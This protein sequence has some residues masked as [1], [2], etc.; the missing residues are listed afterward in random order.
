[1]C[2]RPTRWP[3]SKVIWHEV[4]PLR[5]VTRS[6]ATP[7]SMRST[8]TT[9]SQPALPPVEV[10][11][12]VRLSTT[13]T[14]ARSDWASFVAG[15]A[16]MQTHALAEAGAKTSARRLILSAAHA[17]QAILEVR[18]VLDDL[19]EANDSDRVIQRHLAIVDL[20]QEVHELFRA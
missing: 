20:L 4:T 2:V 17:A 8:R 7:L 1:M 19:R 10:P 6:A 13:P 18:R 14:S 11:S 15:C 3:T 5:T 9:N 16:A 12:S